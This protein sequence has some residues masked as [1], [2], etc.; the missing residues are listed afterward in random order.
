MIDLIAKK[1]SITKIE[2]LFHVTMNGL[3]TTEWL[4]VKVSLKKETFN[5]L[6][7]RTLTPIHFSNHYNNSNKLTL[8]VITMAALIDAI[9]RVSMKRM[10]VQMMAVMIFLNILLI[11]K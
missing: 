5:N 10:M 8:K 7:N 2:E 3:V 4:L 1:I 11:M 9:C 6:L